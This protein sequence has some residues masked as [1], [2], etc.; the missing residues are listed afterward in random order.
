M[1]IQ[2]VTVKFVVLFTM[3]LLVG[4]ATS[5]HKV[6]SELVLRESTK[7]I[8]LMPMDIE[9]SAL[10]AGGIL[11]PNA[12][13]TKDAKIFVHEAIR[14]KIASYNN[15]QVVDLEMNPVL[16][17]DEQQ[18]L[19]TQL[20]KLHEAVGH[21]ILKHKY[22]QPFNLPSKADKFDWT[23]G[24]KST[25]LKRKFGADYALFIYLRDSYA[26]AGRVA[27]IIVASAFGVGI[28]GGQQVG[29]ASLVD[30]N[31]GEVVWFNRLI[32]GVG[33]LRDKA[34]ATISIDLLLTDFPT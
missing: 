10:T 24:E 16:L 18:K 7:S 30:L 12:S 25:F 5:V 9:L 31:T 15:A 20:I 6:S 26:T 22:L 23:L 2:Q 8:L 19:Q 13:W 17:D 4:C 29:F 27:F 33:D 21:T 14:E 3:F 1:K 28:P 11:K 34:N 32:R